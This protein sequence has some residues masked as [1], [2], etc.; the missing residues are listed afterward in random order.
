LKNL[1]LAFSV[2]KESLLRSI[3]FAGVSYI[4][5]QAKQ[6]PR[7]K[8]VWI[9]GSTTFD[10]GAIAGFS[11]GTSFSGTHGTIT[12]PWADIKNPR[13]QKDW[14][15]ILIPK[16]S[17]RIRVSSVVATPTGDVEVPIILGVPSPGGISENYGQKNETIGITIE[18]VTGVASR[19]TNYSTT[20]YSGGM[21]DPKV[22]ADLALS[23][24][25]TVLLYETQLVDSCID[26]FP[27]ALMAADEVLAN[28]QNDLNPLTDEK[29]T[30]YGDRTGKIVYRLAGTPASGNPFTAKAF[31]PTFNFEIKENLIM[32]GFSIEPEK[33][34]FS[35]PM[36]NPYIDLG[37]RLKL[38]FSRGAIDE[39][40][41]VYAVSWR[42]RPKSEVMTITARRELTL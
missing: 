2:V 18:D 5:N 36:I 23:P 25:E 6:S 26:I 35:I 7:L 20:G 42:V 40:V 3:G 1:S 30:R 29:R 14:E 32:K 9:D 21:V 10:L 38:Q 22:V 17:V 19:I 33:V 28:R 34:R 41:E 15:N 31:T 27:N 24:I 39:I 13:S 11:A 37:S 16:D 12:L 8:A 4:T